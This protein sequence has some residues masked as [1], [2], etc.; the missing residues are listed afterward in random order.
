VRKKLSMLVIALAV[1]TGGVLGL[2]TPQTASAFPTCEPLCWDPACT[3]V[4]HGWWTS[5]GCIYE[6]WCTVE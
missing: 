5:S 3:C 2:F 4:F 1:L 6:E